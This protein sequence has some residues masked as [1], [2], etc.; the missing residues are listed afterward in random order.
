ML[1]FGNVQDIQEETWAKMYLYNVSNGVKIVT[2]ALSKH[3]PSYVV[4]NGQRALTSY[5][6]Q[7]QTCD[8]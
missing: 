8:S 4:I 1:Q 5:D 2:M 6:G 7:T 3:I